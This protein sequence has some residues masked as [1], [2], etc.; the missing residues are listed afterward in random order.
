LLQ[1]HQL[2]PHHGDQQQQQQQQI[3]R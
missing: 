3:K 1:P 2:Q